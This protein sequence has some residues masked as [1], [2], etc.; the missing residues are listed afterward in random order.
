[1]DDLKAQ[2]GAGPN[3]FKASAPAGAFCFQLHHTHR[4]ELGV[5]LGLIY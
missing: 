2:P 1:M 5:L 3:L 4:F